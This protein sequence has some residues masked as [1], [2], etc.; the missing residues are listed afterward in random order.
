MQLFL[1]KVK[2]QFGLRLSNRS[3]SSQSNA[4]LLLSMEDIFW[5]KPDFANVM[6]ASNMRNLTQLSVSSFKC[7]YVGA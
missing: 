6:D 4:Q 2:A 7:R 5:N 1:S 3:R